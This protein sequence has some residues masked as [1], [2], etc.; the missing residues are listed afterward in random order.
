MVS[1]LA[2]ATEC[3]RSGPIGSTSR[4]STSSV[5]RGVV[6]P[7]ASH[8][9]GTGMVRA[10]GEAMRAATAGTTP[11][12]PSSRSAH[13]DPTADSDHD[14]VRTNDRLAHAVVAVVTKR[15]PRGASRRASDLASVIVRPGCLRARW[16]RRSLHDEV[17]AEVRADG[18]A[19][20]GGLI[21]NVLGGGAVVV[22]GPA[23]PG[24]HLSH[25]ERGVAGRAAVLVLVV[26]VGARVLI[27]LQGLLPVEF[28]VVPPVPVEG[29]IDG[30]LDL[31]GS[32][33]RCIR[34]RTG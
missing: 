31:R 21:R 28:V 5:R 30:L 24:P 14:R 6:G 2:S 23:E 12:P 8:S 32:G 16:R 15:C 18:G 13:L 17:L 10:D 29:D 22:L 9:R 27:D 34:A 19:A 26:V 11:G 7:T 1:T 3:S 4:Q 25:V 20:R 33:A